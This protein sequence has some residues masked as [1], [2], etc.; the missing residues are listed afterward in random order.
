MDF[1]PEVQPGGRSTRAMSWE[2]IETAYNGDGSA[3]SLELEQRRATGEI[4]LRR[5]AFYDRNAGR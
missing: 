5:R 2:A 3:V 4:L 1:A